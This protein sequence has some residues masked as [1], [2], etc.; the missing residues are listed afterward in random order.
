VFGSLTEVVK[1]ARYVRVTF[2]EL[3][4]YVHSQYVDY[5]WLG[6]HGIERAAAHAE[7][8]AGRLLSWEDN[9]PQ[10]TVRVDGAVV[11]AV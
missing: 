7:A 8:S 6:P 2:E 5:R 3:T 11:I 9:R 10:N 4:I 1:T